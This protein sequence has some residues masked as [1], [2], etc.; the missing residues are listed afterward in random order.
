M[1]SGCV[2]SALTEKLRGA[3]LSLRLAQ[4]GHVK[5]DKLKNN[6]LLKK[7]AVQLQMRER[8]SEWEKYLI[9]CYSHNKKKT[10]Q[11]MTEFL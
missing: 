3:S 1:L 2:Y 8:E 11:A 7:S 10:L 5:H 6:S 4:N 9:S